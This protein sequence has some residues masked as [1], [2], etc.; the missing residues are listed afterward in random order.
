[1]ASK[2]LIA[3]GLEPVNSHTMYHINLMILILLFVNY[4]ENFYSKHNY[5]V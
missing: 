3:A 5:S 1:M 4:F 2:P